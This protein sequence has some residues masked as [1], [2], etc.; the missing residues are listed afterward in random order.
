MPGGT[1]PPTS[2]STVWPETAGPHGLFRCAADYCKAISRNVRADTHADNR[3]MQHLLEENGFLP[4]GTIH[5]RDGTPRLAYHWTADRRDLYA[6][7]RL[8][9]PALPHTARKKARRMMRRAFSSLFLLQVSRLLL[10]LIFGVRQI[11]QVELQLLAAVG[12]ADLAALQRVLTNTISSSQTGQ[13]VSKYS[14]SSSSSS[15]YSSSS[16]SSS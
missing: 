1:T 16:S 2:P 6:I 3:T 12:A 13:M 4:C 8:A 11:A 15:S 9:A 7:H 10:I 14:S 5:V